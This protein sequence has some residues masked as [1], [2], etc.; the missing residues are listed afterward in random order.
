MIL[1]SSTRR[2]PDRTSNYKERLTDNFIF[3][4]DTYLDPENHLEVPKS[5]FET[6]GFETKGRRRLRYKSVCYDV[7]ELKNFAVENMLRRKNVISFFFPFPLVKGST[8]IKNG[9]FMCFDSDQIL[10]PSFRD[11][12][13]HFFECSIADGYEKIGRAS[14]RERV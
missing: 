3:T 10:G 12:T 7:I 2:D 14:C 8:V 4:S 5:L 1:R 9:K 13:N 6:N 11:K